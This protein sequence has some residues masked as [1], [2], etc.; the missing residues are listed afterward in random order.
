MNQRKAGMVILISANVDFRAK[1][2]YR[3]IKF[4]PLKAS[5]R[6]NDVGSWL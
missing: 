2:V 5:K 4:A 1:K 6:K 3:D